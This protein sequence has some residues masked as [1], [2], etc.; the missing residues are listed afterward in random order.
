MEEM[1]RTQNDSL[2]WNY[3]P[4]INISSQLMCRNNESLTIITEM[5][6]DELEETDYFYLTRIS[7]DS[8]FYLVS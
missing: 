1:K 5:E 4:G 3:E 6:A 7:P 8:V 2:E